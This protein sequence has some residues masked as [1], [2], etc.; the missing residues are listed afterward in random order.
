MLFTYLGLHVS[1]SVLFRGSVCLVIGNSPLYNGMCGHAEDCSILVFGSVVSL[2]HWIGILH[3]LNQIMFNNG[4]LVTYGQP[5]CRSY[6]VVL[7]N[8]NS[9]CFQLVYTFLMI[10]SVVVYQWPCIVRL[11]GVYEGL[12]S[13]R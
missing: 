13:I 2:T 12:V 11:H 7:T 1:N 10:M 5:A 6:L 8:V 4:G 9:S 3:I